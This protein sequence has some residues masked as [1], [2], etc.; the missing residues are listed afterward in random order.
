M[1][2]TIGV[3]TPWAAN[4]APLGWMFCQGQILSIAEYSTVFSLLGTT[5]GGDGVNT[6]ALPDFRGRI[7]LGTGQGPGLSN[8]VLGQMMG[9][10]GNTIT[11]GQ[12]AQ[13]THTLSVKAAVQGNVNS[14]NSAAPQNNYPAISPAAIY[15]SQPT[16]GVFGTTLPATVTVG[17][18]GANTPLNNIQPVL[19]LNYV[20]CIEGV[21]PSRS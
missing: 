16:A 7:A 6:F 12:M 21:Y 18:A 9:T 13:H 1:E 2:G 17:A 8:Q 10:E 20:I 4:F 19:C 15:S 14:A 11:Q 3:V 5:Y